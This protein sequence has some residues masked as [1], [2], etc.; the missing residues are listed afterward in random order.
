MMRR[1]YKGKPSLTP[2]ER[3]GNPLWRWVV[4]LGVFLVA[5]I[6]LLWSGAA[7]TSWLHAWLRQPSAPPPRLLPAA[8]QMAL[9]AYLAAPASLEGQRLALAG[10]VNFDGPALICPEEPNGETW[11][12]LELVA[13][14]SLAGATLLIPLTEAAA[15]NHI[16]AQNHLYTADGATLLLGSGVRASGV[17]VCPAAD[18]CRLQVDRLDA[19]EAAAASAPEAAAP[20][21]TVAPTAAAV[22]P[23]LT[24]VPTPAC[25]DAL[26]VTA[27]QVGEVRCVQ[28]TVL[29]AYTDSGV[30]YIRFSKERSDFYLLAYSWVWEEAKAGACIQV[31]G[32]I[33]T[34]GPAQVI[35]IDAKSEKRLCPPP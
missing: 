16:D 10:F 17:V 34:L 5:L 9:E 4:A 26:S 12:V 31:S 25:L 2:Y 29:L 22:A 32:E 8:P 15:P 21:A 33:Q 19:S 3:R 14:D 35:V 6:F 30:T 24:P 7:D 27:A 28:G 13:P 11:C 20:S 18:S 1:N 23:T